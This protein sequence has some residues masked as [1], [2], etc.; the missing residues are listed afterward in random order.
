MFGDKRLPDRYW[1]K[2]R[3]DASGCWVWTGAKRA[4]YGQISRGARGEGMAAAHRLSYEVLVGPIPEGLQLDHMCRRRDCVNPDH[5]RP[6][7]HK[8]NA[9]NVAAHRDSKSGV[10][11]VWW[12]ARKRRWEV[13]VCSHGRKHYGGQY[14]DLT[15]AERA[16]IALRNRLHTNNLADRKASA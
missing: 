16:A 15:E 10:R 12:A 1:A 5:L 14:E 7:T 6:V 2:V 11:G 3:P 13:Q 4:G 8:Q 9:E